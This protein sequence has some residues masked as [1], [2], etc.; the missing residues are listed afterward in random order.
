MAEYSKFRVDTRKPSSPPP[1]RS[2]DCQVH[3][4]GDPNKYPLR[5]GSAYPP[6]PDATIE[7]ALRMHRA[8]GIDYGVVVQSTAHGTN[9]EILYDALATA[10]PN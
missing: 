2:C 6:P 7:E 5:Q 10:G 9:H 3:V 1:P 4:F 8:L